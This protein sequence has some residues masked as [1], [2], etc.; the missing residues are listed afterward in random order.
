M[1][2][3]IVSPACD[4]P[5]HLVAASAKAETG[6]SIANSSPPQLEQARV[7]KHCSYKFRSERRPPCMVSAAYDQVSLRSSVRRYAAV[8]RLV[9]NE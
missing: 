7:A 9:M 2:S 6:T 5:M 4:K 8:R 3:D 1:V